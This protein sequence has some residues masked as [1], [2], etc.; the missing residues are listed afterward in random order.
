M[1]GIGASKIDRTQARSF[2]VLPA[3]SNKI[4]TPNRSSR[5]AR[6]AKAAFS[7]FE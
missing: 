1:V 5:T 6:G 3:K 7:R 2:G 4:G